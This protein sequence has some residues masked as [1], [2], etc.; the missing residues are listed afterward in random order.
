MKTINY[1]SRL[2][3]EM[4]HGEQVEELAFA[5]NPIDQQ[6]ESTVEVVSHGMKHGVW[7]SL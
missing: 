2:I 4:F 1:Q 3:V 5:S 6:V 7:Q